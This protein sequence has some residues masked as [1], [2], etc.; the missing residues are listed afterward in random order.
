M[1]AEAAKVVSQAECQNFVLFVQNVC[2]ANFKLYAGS[3]RLSLT[4]CESLRLYYCM[5]S[6]PL[7]DYRRTQTSM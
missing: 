1:Q 5:L 6:I 3:L 2:L 4:L 7:S